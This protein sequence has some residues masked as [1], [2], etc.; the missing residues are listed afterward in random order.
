MVMETQ[1][2]KYG[3]YNGPHKMAT[4]L[5]FSKG[6]FQPGHT[7]SFPKQHQL[8]LDPVFPSCPYYSHQNPGFDNRTDLTER[9]SRKS[10]TVL[11]ELLQLPARSKVVLSSAPWVGVG[12]GKGLHLGTFAAWS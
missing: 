10:E 2:L 11:S 3:D 5:T 12:V 1:Q 9:L 6:D 7:P 8:D 4:V